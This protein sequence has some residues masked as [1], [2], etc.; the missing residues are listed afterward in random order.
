MKL[1]LKLLNPPAST[2]LQASNVQFDHSGGSIGRGADCDFVLHCQE[3]IVS[4]RHANITFGNGQ[5]FIVD[6]S[7][8]GVYLNDMSEAIDRDVPKV[9]S[10]GDRLRVG[11]FDMSVAL[12]HDV[13]LPEPVL[14]SPKTTLP[15]D[16]ANDVQPYL[17]DEVSAPI[18]AQPNR[19]LD[20]IPEL[21]LISESVVTPPLA[22]KTPPKAVE[23]PKPKASASIIP[24]DWDIDF[25]LDAPKVPEVKAKPQFSSS[26]DKLLVQLLKG[27]GLESEVSPD[28][29]S[30]E[31]MAN[32]G[33]T[34]RTAINGVM[35]V[36]QSIYK[37][38]VNLCND[39]KVVDKYGE[40]DALD[41][42]EDVGQFLN[43]LLDGH[44]VQGMSLV[45]DLAKHYQESVEDIQAIYETVDDAVDCAGQ[46]LNP[47]AIAESCKEYNPKAKP[48]DY[49]QD[50]W[51]E[52]H[53]SFKTEVG[54]QFEAKV[55]ALHGKRLQN[56]Q[57]GK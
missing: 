16:P 12:I 1:E 9:I 37:A 38:K 31:V 24:E 42:I 3:K 53:G 6:V 32:I 57:K 33:R 49:Y 7:A 21:D 45:A 47:D 13:D 15:A 28:Q 46:T 4:R 51:H 26:N 11:G 17:L 56:N 41:H 27:M 40:V 20:V 48:W 29:L 2:S 22:Q 55:L 8:N 36:R 23:S 52:L 43:A 54:R 35:L 50:Q 10:H 18:T 25:G 34:L 39:F 14:D 44:S 30:S 5:F 19:A